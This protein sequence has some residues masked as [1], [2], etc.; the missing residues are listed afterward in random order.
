MDSPTGCEYNIYDDT[1][2]TLIEDETATMYSRCQKQGVTSTWLVFF[3]CQQKPL[4]SLPCE[5]VF[6][7]MWSGNIFSISFLPAPASARHI[8]NKVFVIQHAWRGNL[9]GPDIAEYHWI[10]PH[11]SHSHTLHLKVNKVF[12][13][14]FS[15]SFFFTAAF[16]HFSK[17]VERK[18][19]KNM[20]EGGAA[21][22]REHTNEME[23]S[24]IVKKKKKKKERERKLTPANTPTGQTGCF[25]LFHPT[26][27]EVPQLSLDRC[28]TIWWH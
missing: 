12:F 23:L 9:R 2:Q 19:R 4:F 3:S 16:V 17:S 5:E 20:Q 13:F 18:E 1:T 10:W 27:Y 15:F 26:E 22:Q 24:L 14:S 8:I 6:I 21:F 11:G 25:F 7:H 28:R